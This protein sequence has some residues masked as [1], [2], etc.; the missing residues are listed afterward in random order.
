MTRPFV[1][2]V[3]FLLTL[4]AV[5]GAAAAGGV[6]LG[7]DDGD[8]PTV[9][10][11]QYRPD[12]LLSDGTPG[13]A[14]VTMSADAEPQTI[15]ID[16]G[17]SPQREEPGR[18]PFPGLLL[19]PETAERDVLPLANT[20]IENGHDVRIYTP[21]EDR[22]R[23]SGPGEE[24]LSPIGQELADADALITFRTDYDDAALEDIQSFVEAD[25]RVVMATDPDD[26]FDRP[27]ALSLKSTLGVSTRPGYVYNLAEN[28][29]NYQRVYAEPDGDGPL[30]EGVDR[31]V[32]STAT[33]VDA[34]RV[35]TALSPTTNTELSTTRAE[36]T[37]PVLVRNEN[38]VLVGDTEFL[39]P[40]NTQR[41]DNDVLVG[42]LADFLVTNERDP[43]TQAPQE[44]SATGPTGP[45]QPGSGPT[46]PGTETPG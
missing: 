22:R 30:T 29:L 44:E 26:Q 11:Q 37:A 42:N 16:A 20:L 9:E 28:D 10:T 19:G 3:A 39:T 7:P 27:T 36:T 12:E 15:V 18:F 31:V 43:E 5:V 14:D 40:E 8:P 23:P 45:R 35:D 2:G 24:G 17:L 4:G 34:T 21:P 32:V 33:P 46:R 25:G 13:T 41:A 1:L 6:L 38:V